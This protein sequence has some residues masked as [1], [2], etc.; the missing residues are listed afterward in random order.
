MAAP[1]VCSSPAKAEL[2][3]SRS[4]ERDQCDNG[5]SKRQILNLVDDIVLD[6]RRLV[7]IRRR[8]VDD[9]QIDS[10]RIAAKKQPSDDLQP[11]IHD[12]IL[13]DR[14]RGCKRVRRSGLHDDVQ[15]NS[16]QQHA[17]GVNAID[18]I[19]VHCVDV[20]DAELDKQRIAK[21]RSAATVATDAP[22]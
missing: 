13:L 17:R 3:H 9:L 4:T 19:A 6:R 5:R 20:D 8:C 12:D 11:A 1:G 14:R 15:R 18:F 22:T 7:P 16:L 21:R 2:K 10:Q